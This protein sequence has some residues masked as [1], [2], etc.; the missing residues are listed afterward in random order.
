MIACVRLPHFAATLAQQA[1]PALTA[2]PLVLGTPPEHPVQVYA[3]C[4]IAAAAGITVGMSLQEAQTRCPAL[5]ILP[6]SPLRDR[7]T[8]EHLM[9]RLAAFTT[10]LEVDTGLE[11]RAD[12]RSRRPVVTHHHLAS[13]DQLIDLDLGPL[14]MAD[15][16]FLAQQIQTALSH[17]VHIAPTLGLASG[18]FTARMAATSLAPG[19]IGIIAKGQEATFLATFPVE[20]LPID[21][22]TLRQLHLLGLHM[23]GQVAALPVASVVNTFG[24]P[25]RIFHRLAS[26]RDTTPIAHYVP[27]TTERLVRH[28]DTALQDRR[29]RDAVLGMMV[30]ILH[31]RLET[32]GYR[33]RQIELLLQLE[34]G[35]SHEAEVL[36][37]QPSPSLNH[38]R[39]MVK[40]LADRLPLTAGITSIELA[41]GDL[42]PLAAQ[43]LSLF[44]QTPIAADQLHD[45]LQDLVA[46][47][48]DDCFYW[49]TPSDPTARLPERRFRLDKVV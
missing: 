9:A 43:Q 2:Y 23:L 49:M 31:E 17:D 8:R 3:A 18:K 42:A 36:L 1:D 29:N 28:L 14:K 30:K 47:Y 22:E 26:G 20:V 39:E 7:R 16:T 46:R 45:L 32:A 34:N 35:H 40:T 33:P 4:A 21:R 10:Q 27:P 15:A 41:L 38:L 44:P 11:L 48:G 37:H 5:Q 25:G 24:K 19:E 6:A 12:A 13:H